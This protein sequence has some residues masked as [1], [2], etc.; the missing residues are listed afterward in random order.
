MV[1][2]RSPLLIGTILV[3]MSVAAVSADPPRDEQSRK[4]D[5]LAVQQAMAGARQYLREGQPKQAVDLLEGQLTR[6][7][8]HH[9]FLE[10]L[11]DAY[12]DCIIKLNLEH[13]TAAAQRYAQRLA[14]LDPQA[15][16]ELTAKV[17]DKPVK[18]DARPRPAPKVAPTPL[19]NFAA[20]HPSQP[21]AAP[22]AVLP[23]AAPPTGSPPRAPVVIA[24]T[25]GAKPSAVRGKMEDAADDPFHPANQ[26]V[27]SNL[28]AAG[29]A[30]RLVARANDEFTRGRYREARMFYEQAFE[31]DQQAT[32][33]CRD[34]WAYCMLN[35]VVAALNQPGLGGKALPEL[36]KEVHGALALSKTPTLSAEGNKLLRAIELRQQTQPAAAPRA[37]S[38]AAALAMRHYGRNPQ[39]WQV[40]DTS[41]FRIYHN[42][43]R[44]LVER[45]ARVAERTRVDMSRKWF[46]N[47]GVDWEPKC[48]LV[49]HATAAEYSKQTG[50]PASSPGHSRIESD[51]G[52]HRVVG[53][54]LDLHVDN[55]TMLEAVLPHEA[56]HVVIAG[57]FG[58]FPVPR[59]VD[60][61][62]AVLSEP[63]D[64]VEQHRRNLA[65][66]AREGRLFGVK[67]LLELDNYPQ[68]QLVGVFYA[69][70]VGL[71][72]FLTHQR[73]P[74]VFSAFVRDGLR[75]GWDRALRDHYNWGL[76][77]LQQQWDVHVQADMQRLAGGAR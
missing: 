10:L 5:T 2:P 57:Q 65:K 37:A 53:R 8:G 40:T 13:D 56:T 70:S 39:G 4:L 69:Q 35:D 59:W 17:D 28:D 66:A 44:E 38:E 63:N 73:G 11:R 29:V 22:R 15:A 33:P 45:V 25:T 75:G 52:T 49:L 20:S 43:P 55:P 16:R 41:H 67:E 18:F 30:T 74:Q 27:P 71:V 26:R 31:A 9:G 7:G 42:Q 62:M 24:S 21:A 60:E 32:D 61:G 64:K 19:P 68:P 1:S 12:R 51:R 54:R 76:A 46:G 36:Q 47:D 50:V 58:P 14:I 6:A 23:P 77:D 34:S 3:T 72:E 48:E